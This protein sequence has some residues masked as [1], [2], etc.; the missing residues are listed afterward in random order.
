MSGSL[1]LA[2]YPGVGPGVAAPRNDHEPSQVVVP[3]V[4]VGGDRLGVGQ[5]AV[6]EPKAR[7]VAL[8]NELDLDRR[9]ARRDGIR[10]LGARL[11]APGEDEPVRSVELGFV[12]G[13][14]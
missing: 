14:V 12:Y 10:A 5:T 3:A 2:A 8:R 1:H 4:P 9:R 13:G 6:D 7:P 11:P